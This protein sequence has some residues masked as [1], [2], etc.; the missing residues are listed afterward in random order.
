MTKNCKTCRFDCD[1]HCNVGTYYAEQGQSKTC[2]EGELWQ[3][4]LTNINKQNNMIKK[5]GKYWIVIGL[6]MAVSLMLYFTFSEKSGKKKNHEIENSENKNSDEQKTSNEAP[7]E[8]ADQSVADGYGTVEEPT[9]SISEDT[10]PIEKTVYIDKTS[11]DKIT[12]YWYVSYEAGDVSGYG[13]VQCNGPYF[14]P[15]V[16]ACKISDNLTKKYSKPY[17]FIMFQTITEVSETTFNNC[18]ADWKD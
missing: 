1:T 16:V 15:D 4:K 7:A 10:T 8:V 6:A 5:I 17:T 14:E 12:S 2:Y 13:V 3:P 18:P 9:K 11:G